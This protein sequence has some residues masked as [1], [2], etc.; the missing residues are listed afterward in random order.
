MRSG[1]AEGTPNAWDRPKNNM[2]IWVENDQYNEAAT[3]VGNVKFGQYL[4]N[5]VLESSH[6]F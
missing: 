1:G 5:H 3:Q 4:S 6:T 2:A